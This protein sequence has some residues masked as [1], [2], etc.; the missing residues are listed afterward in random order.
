M[1]RLP[2]T[3]WPN[4]LKECLNK[5]NEFLGCDLNYA[6]INYYLSNHYIGWHQDKE[7]DIET[8]PDG[9]TTIASIS[10]GDEREFRI[11]QIYKKG[12][13]PTKIHKKI[14]ENGSLCTMEKHTQELCKHSV[15]L[16]KG[17][18]NDRIN[19]TFRKMKIN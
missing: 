12:E 6:F 14:L 13:T 16:K 9:Q 17:T 2:H 18:T 19:I 15:P 11:R 5:I 8:T 4:E 10:L 7:S 3:E 1:E